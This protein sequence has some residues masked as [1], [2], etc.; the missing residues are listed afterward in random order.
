MSRHQLAKELD[1]TV[2]ALDQGSVEGELMPLLP[3]EELAGLAL[4]LRASLAK[5]VE[6]LES[7]ED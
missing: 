4:R 3:E 1:E 5:L 2:R 7:S 6:Q